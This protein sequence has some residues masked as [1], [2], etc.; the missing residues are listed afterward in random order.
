METDNG[1]TIILDE[2]IEPTNSLELEILDVTEKYKRLSRNL[3]ILEQQYF[4]AK[5]EVSNVHKRL[6]ELKREQETKK[7]L[8]RI[9]ALNSTLDDEWVNKTFSW[10]PALDELL[11]KK[12]QFKEFRPKQLAAIN[13]T[14]SKKDV[15]LVMATGGGKSLV[16]QL[17]SLVEDGFTLVVSPLIALIDDQLVACERFNISARAINSETDKGEVKETY[18]L[19]KNASKQ[20]QLLYVTPEWIAKS[21]KFQSQLK[22]SYIAKSF[23]RIAIGKLFIIIGFFHL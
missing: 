10:S 20:L 19:M 17:P 12:F 5:T 1:S 3:K 11:T 15:L 14:L 4:D 23:V 2:S 8:S 6:T 22:K 18:E 13:A 16:Y 9:K 21:K 7:S